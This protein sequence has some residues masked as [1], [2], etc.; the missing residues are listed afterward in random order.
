[1][2]TLHAIVKS[3]ERGEVQMQNRFGGGG[4]FNVVPVLTILCYDAVFY[5][6]L[7]ERSPLVT[8]RLSN[9][10]KNQSQLVQSIE[11]GE[12][13]SFSVS[14]TLEKRRQMR[15]P[16]S[17]VLWQELSGESTPVISVTQAEGLKAWN[18]QNHQMQV[19]RKSQINQQANE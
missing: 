16:K 18:H 11:S 13:Q 5:R 8:V 7:G 3:V 17:S 1:M 9:P 6:D 15:P 4:G 2:P 12:V 19:H 14:F 10:D